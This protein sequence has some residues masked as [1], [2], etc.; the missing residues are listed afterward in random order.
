M[1]VKVE[2]IK[3]VNIDGEFIKL[4]SLLKFCAIASTGGEAKHLISSGN[5]SVDKEICMQRGRKIKHVNI[6]E[7]GEY[8][9]LV[10]AHEKV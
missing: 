10:K 1:K 5:V 2:G 4:D 8:K 7:V 9:L 6:V 3:K